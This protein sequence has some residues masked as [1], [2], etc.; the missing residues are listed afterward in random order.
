MP[1]K[2]EVFLEK[3]LPEKTSPDTQSKKYPKTRSFKFALPDFNFKSG[4]RF[5]LNNSEENLNVSL[6]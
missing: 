1:E 2:V 6:W 5:E 4:T 3:S